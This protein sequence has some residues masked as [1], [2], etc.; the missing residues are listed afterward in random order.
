MGAAGPT[1]TASSPS[2]SIPT[3]PPA[4][5]QRATA[6]G[7]WDPDAEGPGNYNLG[8]SAKGKYVYLEGGKRYLPGD[9]PKGTQPYFEDGEATVMYDAPPASE[10]V[11]PTYPCDDCPSSGST[12]VTPAAAAT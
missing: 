8:G 4:I 7:W 10:P 12:A 11:V 1:P 6:L 3:A 9:F 2:R 5:T